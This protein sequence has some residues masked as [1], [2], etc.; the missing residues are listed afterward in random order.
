MAQRAV[1]PWIL[2][3]KEEY[4]T[5]RES[6]RESGSPHDYLLGLEEDCTSCWTLAMASIKA[7]RST[8]GIR[9]LAKKK[10]MKRG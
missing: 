3:A 6:H 8:P 1:P 5:C 4:D 10:E 7:N 9:A 2:E